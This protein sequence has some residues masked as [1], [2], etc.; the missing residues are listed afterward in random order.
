MPQ[1]AHDR[2]H[3]AECLRRR[4]RR[5]PGP[6]GRRRRRA[7]LRP[8]RE[9][10]PRGPGDQGRRDATTRSQHG[11]RP[12]PGP[13]QRRAPRRSPTRAAAPSTLHTRLHGRPEPAGQRGPSP[14]PTGRPQIDVHYGIE[15]VSGA[16]TSLRAGALADLYVGNN[17]SG[18]GV[19]RAPPRRASSAGATRPPASSTACR[20]SRPGA[21]TRRA[22][23]S[24]SSTTSRG[25]GLNNT[26]DSA[27]PD[28]GVGA[29][30]AARQPR[31][32][33]R[34]G[35]DVRWLLAAP[36][37]PGTVTPP[38]ARRRR[39]AR[40]HRADARAAAAARRGQDRQRQRPQGHGSS[41]RS[42]RA[43]KFIELTGR[44]CRSRSAPRSTPQGP[45]EARLRRPTRTA[46]PSSPGSTTASS[47]SARPRARSRSPSSRSPRRSLSCPKGKGKAQRGGQEEE[48][49][50]AVG[51]RQGHVPHARQVQLGDRP[52]HQV[53]RDRPLRRHAARRSRR[54]RPR[55]RLQAQAQERHRQGRQAVPRAQ[56]QVSWVSVLAGF[57]VAH[58]VGDYLLQTDWQARHKRG[59][60]RQRPGRAPRAGRARHDLH[61]GL[62]AGAD[63]DRLRARAGL[64]DRRRR[65]RSSSR[66]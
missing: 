13:R 12:P 51:R 11:F 34:R 17:D 49:A 7:V 23:S 20:R 15:N 16:P 29:E 25:D 54:A 59:G 31:P 10:G 66:T 24:A 53:G 62:P 1:G 32:G 43:K 9:P 38:A 2:R 35:I 55:A 58:M 50:Q 27:A 45:R 47:R 30:F 4:P 61:A 39:P 14:T 5:D 44:R 36:A 48:D 65:A 21:A 26:V 63:L 19:D 60:L 46:R 6:P 3:A 33:E 22:T 52:R 37:P 41:S 18:N 40:R 56:E 57:L 64:G 42:R 8:G 28:N